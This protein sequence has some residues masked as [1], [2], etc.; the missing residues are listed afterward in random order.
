MTARQ[1]LPARRAHE[2][3]SFPH[4][5]YA[6]TAG[7]GRF[8]DGT[9]GEIFLTTSAKGGSV[10][11]AWSRDAAIITS[12]SLQHGVDAETIRMALTRDDHGKAAGPVG[13]LLDMLAGENGP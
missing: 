6:Y 8:D 12:L 5:G 13:E 10:L 1:Q 9:V 11:E 7:V 3:L 2:V 4:G